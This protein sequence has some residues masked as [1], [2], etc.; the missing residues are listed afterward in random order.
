MHRVR[1]DVAAPESLV[2]SVRDRR[3]RD[4]EIARWMREVI[5]SAA[6]TARRRTGPRAGSFSF[7]TDCA[8]P[9][10]GRESRVEG[11]R[12]LPGRAANSRARSAE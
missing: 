5:G 12:L 8:Q 3:P 6:G 7:S 10:L 1:A 11:A 2:P 9:Q 4:L